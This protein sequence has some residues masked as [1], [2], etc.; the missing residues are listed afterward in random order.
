MD[1]IINDLLNR[2][3]G[4][5]IGL[6]MTRELSPD[7]TSFADINNNRIVFNLN[8]RNQKQLAFQL[9]HELAHFENGD[10]SNGLLYFTPR[11]NKVEFNANVGAIKML[12]PYYVDGKDSSQ[13]NIYDF[14]DC[15]AIPSH[16]EPAI[17]KELMLH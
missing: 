5:G 17:E 7:T 4:K 9:A 11:K 12:A 8:Y 14:M 1:N 2:A 3:L 15:F 6:I 13:I 16:L 10:K